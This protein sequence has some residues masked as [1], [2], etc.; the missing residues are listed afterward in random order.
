MGDASAGLTLTLIAV[1]IGLLHRAR[2]AARSIPLRPF[3]L[4]FAFALLNDASTLVLER[5]LAAAPHPFTG[6]SKALYLIYSGI[7]LGWPCGVAGAALWT[8]FPK[9]LFAWGSVGT[10]AG[11]ALGMVATYPLPADRITK[12]HL[13]VELAACAVTACCAIWTWSV[14]RWGRNH[15]LALLVA[16]G[17]LV[18][19]IVGPYA[20]DPFK[21][22]EVARVVYIIEFAALAVWLGRAPG[23]K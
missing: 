13:V 15:V 21:S 11:L 6:V 22:W 17:E 14:Q 7:V 4:L 20:T 23:A 19:A 12:L 16:G 2:L 18:I 1:E 5:L 9:R 8:F 10:W 3:L